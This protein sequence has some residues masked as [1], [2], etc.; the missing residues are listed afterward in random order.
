M[1]ERYNIL[2]NFKRRKA[3]KN[4]RCGNCTDGREGNSKKAGTGRKPKIALEKQTKSERNK[5]AE[6]QLAL[7]D[8]FRINE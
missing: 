3:R 8:I 2:G 7:E 5:E 4:V 6:R 1:D